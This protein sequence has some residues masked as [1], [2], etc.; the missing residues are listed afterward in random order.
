MRR[1]VRGVG[2]VFRAEGPEEISEIRS[3]QGGTET[4]RET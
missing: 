3:H 2:R 1:I 4:Q